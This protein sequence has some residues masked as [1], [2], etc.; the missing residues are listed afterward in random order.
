MILIFLYSSLN[1]L[2]AYL[3]AQIVS[4]IVNSG[5]KLSDEDYKYIIGY[6]VGLDRK[7]VV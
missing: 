4:I 2:T 5:G 7:S 3:T 1:L 6:F